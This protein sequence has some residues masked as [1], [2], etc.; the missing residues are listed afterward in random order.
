MPSAW[1]KQISDRKFVVVAESAIQPGHQHTLPNGSPTYKQA[2]TYATK[3]G[4]TVLEG[5]CTLPRMGAARPTREI[6]S[7]DELRRLMKGEGE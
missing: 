2:V 4:Y 6:V 7:K 1:I 3:Q 5:E